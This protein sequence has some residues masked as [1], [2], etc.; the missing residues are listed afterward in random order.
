MPNDEKI[1]ELVEF[2]IYFKLSYSTGQKG[3]CTIQLDDSSG[4]IITPDT[5]YKLSDEL[6]VYLYLLSN[7]AI[8]NIYKT[9]TDDKS[10]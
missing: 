7:K 4:R 9:I 8:A 1:T 2:M 3:E 5:I 10:K 6:Y